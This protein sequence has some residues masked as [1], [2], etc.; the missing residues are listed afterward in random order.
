MFQYD[1]NF[2]DKLKK[3]NN[4]NEGSL[5]NNDFLQIEMQLKF[6][7]NVFESV[8]PKRIIETGTHKGFFSYIASQYEGVESIDTF[9]ISDFSIIAVYLINE[10][11]GD[12][13]ITFHHGDSTDKL[14]KF[15]PEY[16]IDFAFVDGGHD[17]MT[18]L[19]DL[20]NC[21]HLQVKNILVDDFSGEVEKAANRF[22]GKCGYEIISQSADDRK[23]TLLTKRGL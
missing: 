13:R 16:N 5:F 10:L 7:F 6:I 8:K 4:S 1:C 11:N 21:A 19:V 2:I 15:F 22:C 12:K 14:S 20:I 18:C 9:D 17:Y 3:I 23:L